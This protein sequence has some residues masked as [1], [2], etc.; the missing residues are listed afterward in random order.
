MNGEVKMTKKQFC[1]RGNGVAVA[2]H[3]SS[4]VTVELPAK[5]AEDLLSG[6]QRRDKRL[7]EFFAEF[8]GED[9]LLEVLRTDSGGES[10]HRP[11]DTSEKGLESLIVRAMTGRVDL[12][13]Q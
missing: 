8:G 11:T 3:S 2:P 9:G 1:V 5:A 13:S 7:F 12:Q 10:G 4:R 6:F